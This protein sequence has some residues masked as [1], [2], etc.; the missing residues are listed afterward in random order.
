MKPGQMI[1]LNSAMSSHVKTPYS[2]NKGSRIKALAGLAFASLAGGVSTGL[3][4][5]FS[6]WVLAAF[7][8]P[9]I[10]R[11][12]KPE[13]TAPQNSSPGDKSNTGSPVETKTGDAVFDD[14]RA[15]RRGIVNYKI[16]AKLDT[17][18]NKIHGELE[19]VWLNTTDKNAER[20]PFHLYMNAFKHDET[21]FMRE[22]GG[23]HRGNRLGSGEWGYIDVNSIMVDGHDLTSNVRIAGCMDPPCNHDAPRDETVMTVELDQPIRAGSKA[24]I[25]IRFTTRLPKVFART[26]YAG[27]FFMIAQWFPKIGVLEDDG[28]RCHPFH[29]NAE[30]YSN[31]GDYKVKLDLPAG[32]TLGSTGKT[33]KVEEKGDRKIHHLHARDVHDFAIATG[34]SLVRTARRHDNI[35]FILIAPKSLQERS[36]PHLDLTIKAQDIL[37]DLLGPYPY[38]HLTIVVPPEDASGAG[39]MEYPTLFT[40]F[41]SRRGL[42]GFLNEEQTTVHELIH[43]YFQGLLASDEARE[44]WLDEGLTTYVTGIVMDRL[45]GAD[46]SF[47]SLWGL[48][49]GYYPMMR[50]CMK[51]RPDWDPILAASWEYASMT[52]YGVT[53]YCKATMLLKSLEGLIGKEKMRALLRLYV[54]RYKF[55]HPTTQ[56]FL[57]V[58]EDIG[59]K[60]VSDLVQRALVSTGSL[61]HRVVRIRNRRRSWWARIR[62]F[63]TA[64]KAHSPAAE[65]YTCYE[66]T[67]KLHR[68]GDSAWPVDI[69]I[70]FENNERT[71][72]KWRDDKRWKIIKLETDHKVVRVQLDPER[73]VW[74]DVSRLN[75]GLSVK[76]DN[77]AA[78][79]MAV[80]FGTAL[81]WWMQAVGF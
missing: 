53:T 61:D 24:R 32:F 14:S 28:W 51:H 66:S 52:T 8:D 46:S 77:S 70:V 47:V 59:G 31:F 25:R 42:P 54:S 35:E 48:N 72:R 15:D 11:T 56:D 16:D 69:E 43:Q 3:I 50:L 58:V 65:T 23:T 75:D 18:E 62:N 27:D 5:L 44:P 39:G 29:A 38:D 26:G 7:S 49:A 78:K 17:E 68:R 71:R 63:S 20:L 45:Y 80:R 10:P 2:E 81:Q 67:I 60:E 9:S 76:P 57:G 34:G 12:V 36:L 64:K 73:K 19:L 74:L 33:I 4:F 41:V 22:T 1:D 37:N 21:L 30:F 79:N 13:V 6:A 55:K 40:T